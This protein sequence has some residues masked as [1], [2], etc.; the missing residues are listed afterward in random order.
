MTNIV[1]G[2]V[3]DNFC[4]PLLMNLI[5]ADDA[6]HGD[7]APLNVGKFVFQALFGW[8]KHQGGFFA[9][10]QVPDLDEPRDIGWPGTVCIDLVNLVLIDELNSVDAFII[11]MSSF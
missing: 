6:M 1:L 9:K 8:I 2:I 5:N 11:H 4:L 7:I 10:D 3:S